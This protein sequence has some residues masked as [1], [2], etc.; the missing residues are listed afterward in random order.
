[1]A[2]SIDIVSY[3][4]ESFMIYAILGGMFWWYFAMSEFK[5]SHHLY[6]RVDYV[7]KMKIL[8]SWKKLPKSKNM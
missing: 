3:K 8:E 7:F 2:Q 5:V 4:T 1:M 6:P